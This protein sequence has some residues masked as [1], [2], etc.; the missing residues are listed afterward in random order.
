MLIILLA[1][2]F[3]IVGGVTLAFLVDCSDKSLREKED[4]Q[5]FLQL[6]VLAALPD[7]RE[8]EE[9]FSESL[10]H[11]LNKIEIL[12][13]ASSHR[14][15]MMVSAVPG[16]GKTFLL[17][18]LSQLMAN[19]DETRRIVVVDVNLRNPSLHKLLGLK[20]SPGLVDLYL[21]GAPSLEQ[22]L[23]PTHLNNL[24]FLAA[25][26]NNPAAID[27]IP[28]VKSDEIISELKSRFDVVLLD[29]PAAVPYGETTSLAKLVDGLLLV[30]RSSG[31][32]R[33]IVRQALINLKNTHSEPL[34]I[35]LNK[36]GRPIPQVIY[37]VLS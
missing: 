35:V 9:S 4:I 5:H 21:A 7:K 36:Q 29:S 13:D 22:I 12:R 20:G 11:L 26:E 37:D 33:E 23:Q 19:M 25:G 2:V 6:P 14:T 31:A 28:S 10:R 32:H 24:F 27:M 16:E 1:I 30:I 3:G 18:H 17:H 34:G 8:N 15:L